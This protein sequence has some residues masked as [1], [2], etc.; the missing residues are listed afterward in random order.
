[1][2]YHVKAVDQAYHLDGVD[3]SDIGRVIIEATQGIIWAIEPWL[4][5]SVRHDP[6]A[7]YTFPVPKHVCA[8]GRAGV[9]P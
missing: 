7:Q 8:L 4:Y 9:Y 3:H 5:E 2:S 1:M 6:L